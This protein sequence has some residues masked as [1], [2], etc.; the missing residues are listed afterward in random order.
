MALV[1]VDRDCL[2][3]NEAVA[4]LLP[5]LN[6]PVADGHQHDQENCEDDQGDDPAGGPIDVDGAARVA[7]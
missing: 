3:L 5:P 6:D 7:V 4:F 2:S 1:D